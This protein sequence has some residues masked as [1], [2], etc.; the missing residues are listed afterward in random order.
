M[1]LKAHASTCG[2][3]KAL[4]VFA[5][6][7][8]LGSD[9]PPFGLKYIEKCR[10]LDSCLKIWSALA[11]DDSLARE[12]TRDYFTYFGDKPFDHGS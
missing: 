5:G 9:L 6:L 12:W 7:C 10:S 8:T 3:A 4:Q 1:G 2:C 11:R